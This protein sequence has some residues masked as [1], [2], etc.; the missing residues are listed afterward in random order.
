MVNGV[1][2]HFR[3]WRCLP[4]NEGPAPLSQSGIVGSNQGPCTTNHP[5]RGQPLA[6]Q[7]VA[8]VFGSLLRLKA[9]NEWLPFWGSQWGGALLGQCPYVMTQGIV[10]GMVQGWYNIQK[11]H[12][13]WLNTCIFTNKKFIGGPFLI[14]F[15]VR[16]V[17]NCKQNMY[18]LFC[19]FFLMKFS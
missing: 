1:P 7:W 18:T 3:P 9:A 13:R 11:L 15:I 14:W 5:M 4:A 6:G 8:N 19:V 2:N 12:G 16:S 10:P 17:R